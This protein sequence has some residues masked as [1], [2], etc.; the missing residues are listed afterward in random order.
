M[1][2]I[3]TH[4]LHLILCIVFY[5]WNYM[6]YP[7]AAYALCSMDWVICIV[8]MHS[9]YLY[10]TSCRSQST[11]FYVAFVNAFQLS[12]KVLVVGIIFL[13]FYFYAYSSIDLNLLILLFTDC[14]VQFLICKCYDNFNFIQ[15]NAYQYH[16]LC[17]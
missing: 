13:A 17:L 4:V 6:H 3:S 1:Q 2:Y 7:I 14:S 15:E 16:S 8:C 12:F 9:F 11:L 10:K 5:S